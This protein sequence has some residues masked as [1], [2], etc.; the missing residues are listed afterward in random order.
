MPV[1]KEQRLKRQQRAELGSAGR[2]QAAAS[3]SREKKA[4]LYYAE[5]YKTKDSHEIDVTVVTNM[6][7]SE[8]K[9]EN[10]NK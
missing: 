9:R 4:Y 8:D 3:S 2:R 7:S 10:T 6:W 1:P 5:K